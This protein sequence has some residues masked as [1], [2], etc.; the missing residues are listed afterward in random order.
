MD[1][2][3]SLNEFK[4]IG[5]AG[6]IETRTT[7]NGKKQATV[8]LATNRRLSDG[9]GNWSDK[10]TWHR[11]TFWGPKAELLEKLKIS[12]GDKLYVS[13][14]IDNRKVGEGA[15]AKYYTDFVV[16]QFTPL[17]GAKGAG[18]GG[19]SPRPAAPK[20]AAPAPASASIAGDDEDDLPF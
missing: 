8:S 2:L 1:S 12:K 6:N 9:Q 15:D 20:A 11:L 10:G 16:D 13:G 17:G 4:L 3:G 7:T 19:D 14:Y 18:S 5:N